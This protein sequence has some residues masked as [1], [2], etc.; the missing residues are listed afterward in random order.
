[1]V[2]RSLRTR[3]L[4]KLNINKSR[5]LNDGEKAGSISTL[6]E[7]G[8]SERGEEKVFLG[9][10]SWSLEFGLALPAVWTLPQWAYLLVE[11]MLH[12]SSPWS[13]WIETLCRTLAHKVCRRFICSGYEAG[14][15]LSTTLYTWKWINF[16]QTG[17]ALHTRRKVLKPG[18]R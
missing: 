5:L 6:L 10:F 11:N 4:L 7:P 2:G 12:H 18:E 15:R 16:Q 9:W 13:Q 14:K 8:H 1:M 3:H 17:N